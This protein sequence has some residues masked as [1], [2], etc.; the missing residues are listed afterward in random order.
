MGSIRN[1]IETES[2]VTHR[3]K[4]EIWEM[5]EFCSNEKKEI[6]PSLPILPPALVIPQ[7]S[8]PSTFP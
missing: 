4:G 2:Q 8:L 5:F 7:E 1:F 3:S 6:F